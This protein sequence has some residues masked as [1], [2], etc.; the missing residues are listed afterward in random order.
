MCHGL[1]STAFLVSILFN[2]R[3][4]AHRL[5]TETQNTTHNKSKNSFWTRGSHLTLVREEERVSKMKGMVKGVEVSGVINLKK[6]C[7]EEWLSVHT[8]RRCCV[9]VY[10]R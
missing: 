9:C 3:R 10:L 4:R 2:Y 8:Q 5:D 1:P 6:T 7:S